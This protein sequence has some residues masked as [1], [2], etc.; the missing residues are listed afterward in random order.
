MGDQ[1]LLCVSMALLYSTIVNSDTGSVLRYGL[2]FID[3]DFG[4][5]LLRLQDKKLTHT[6]RLEFGKKISAAGKQLII[7]RIQRCLPVKKIPT[8][9]ILC[10]LAYLNIYILAL[11]TCSLLA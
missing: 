4:L 1:K 9:V 7:N 3:L 5:E 10:A 2:D 6:A 11:E 8:T